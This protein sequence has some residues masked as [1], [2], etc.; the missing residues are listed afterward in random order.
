MKRLV[1]PLLI[2]SILLF[3]CT[4]STTPTPSAITSVPV[5]SAPVASDTPVVT[6]APAVTDTPVATE[7]PVP[8]TNV[9]CNELALFLDPAL[10]TGFACQTLPETGGPDNPG[11][12]INPQYTELT[13]TGYVLSDR[14]FT[15]KILV[16]PVQRFSELAPD[17]IPARV[18]ALQILI[19]GGSI[20][21]NALPLLPIFNAGQTFHA[22]DQVI[23]FASGS[24]IRFLT[25]YAQYFAP[26]NNHDVFYTFQGLTS[27]G[28]YWISAILPVSNPILPANGD[29]PPNGQSWDDF[30]NNYTTYI[31][32]I[33]TQ[34]NSQ[35]QE[36]YSPTVTMLDALVS[37]IRIQP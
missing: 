14:F 7:P 35:S 29:N 31:T 37:S 36:S 10:A 26:I 2:L 23:P 28:K 33:V 25:L 34:L 30:G 8:Q 20:G 1:Y 16:F 4:I 21:D 9:T 12:E 18:S 5:T 24:G 13:L 15:P 22:R 6:E 19:G 11:F 32:D 3:A 17:V 27:D